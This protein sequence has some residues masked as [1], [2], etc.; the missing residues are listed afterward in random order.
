MAQTDQSELS[1]SRTPTVAELTSA[2]QAAGS[3]HHEYE[4]TTLKGVYDEQ[5]PMFYAAYVLGRLGDF[6]KPSLLTQWLED[7]PTDGD[8][9]DSAANYVRT[10][11]A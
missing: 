6:T 4:Q 11:V 8:W 5:W 7:A 9:A 3:A 10:E 2:L 1:T